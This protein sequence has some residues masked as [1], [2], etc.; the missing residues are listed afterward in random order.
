MWIKSE[1]TNKGYLCIWCGKRILS[2]FIFMVATEFVTAGSV[3]NELSS[4]CV[5]LKDGQR[6]SGNTRGPDT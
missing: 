5:K 2:D 3:Q 1:A 6:F 4:R